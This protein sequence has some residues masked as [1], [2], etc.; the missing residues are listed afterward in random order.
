[1]KRSKDRGLPA[2][3][4]LSGRLATLAA[5]LIAFIPGCQ[6][7]SLSLEVPEDSPV[8]ERP[9]LLQKR[10][11]REEKQQSE[12]KIFKMFLVLVAKESIELRGV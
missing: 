7:S 12:S 9:R 4:V 6:V 2:T 8:A 10:S 1:M 11:L 3:V 5:G